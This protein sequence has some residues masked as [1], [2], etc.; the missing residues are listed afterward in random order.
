VNRWQ[1]RLA[2]L[3]GD[4]GEELS[5]PSL[6]VQ[7][8]QNVQ[9]SPPPPAFEHSKQIEQGTKPAASP[10]QLDRALGT[11]GDAEAERAAIIEHDGG[12][13]WEWAEGFARLDPDRPPADVPPKRWQRFVDDVGRFLDSP[14]CAV[15]ASLGWRQHDLFGCDRDRPFARIDQCGLLWLLDGANPL[16]LTEN[17]ATIEMPTGARQTWRR[18][19]NEPGR[20]L[21]WE[22][23]P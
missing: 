21:A 4:T 6:S 11:W 12:I 1:Q 10:A 13:P 17:A 8:V 16:A 15:A 22:L 7:N 3:H 18:K 23:P 19:P 5:T 2:E 14:F 9:N 20:V